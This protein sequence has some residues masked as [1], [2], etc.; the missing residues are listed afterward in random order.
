MKNLFFILSFCFVTL[1]SWSQLRLNV[2]GDGAVS[3]NLNVN[4]L[5]ASGTYINSHSPISINSPGTV[6]LNLRADNPLVE[7]RN[8]NNDYLA[9]IQPFGN[10]LYLANRQ[11]GSLYFR[12]SNVNRMTITDVGDVG[13]GVTNPSSKLTINGYEN[14]GTIAGLEVRSGSQ[15]LIMDGNEIDCTSGG[16]HLNY[17]SENDLLVR[18]ASR[19]AEITVAH[20]NGSGSS[21]GFAIQHPGS[22]NV[23]WTF[24]STNG[25]GNLEFYHQGN[26]KAEI[27]SS[28]GAY[29]Q[30]SDR[31][32]KH[33]IK[34]LESVLERVASLNP[35]SYLFRDQVSDR[36]NLG[37][38]AQEVMPLFPELV[39]QGGI[40][41]TDEEIFM[42][43]YSGFGVIAIAAI[44]EMLALEEVKNAELVTENQKLQS[45]INSLADRLDQLESKFL[46]C[47]Q[48]ESN[49]PESQ[50][51][52]ENDILLED[53]PHLLQ[54]VP[55]PFRE[56]TS[57]EYYLPEMVRNAEIFIY[58]QHGKMLRSYP[59]KQTGFGKLT[60]ETENLTTGA[61]FYSLVIDGVVWKSLPMILAK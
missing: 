20:N 33:E 27:A 56:R 28:N 59:L 7:F 25:D 32:L 15:K 13:I 24:Y 47:C 55:N 18:T 30:I 8:S 48:N 31:R 34:P 45:Q 60:V 40:G 57:I 29:I 6:V 21:N 46:N 35:S 14:N 10:D 53:S 58:D 36:S 43:D 3:G 61:Y 16:L 50:L 1:H 12:T 51:I 39:Y 23:Y 5:T 26:Q 2:D 38:I 17:N 42:L 9:F 19:R 44:Q 41:D 52:N 11:S 49:R 37:F 22:N 54:N 4:H